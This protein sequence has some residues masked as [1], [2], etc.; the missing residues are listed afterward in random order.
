MSAREQSLSE[1]ARWEAR[2]ATPEYAFGKEP[3]Y[4]LKSCKTLLPRSGRAL[5][6]AD[7]EGRNG[8]WLAQQGLEVLSLDFSPAAQRK[9][10]AL[11]AERQVEIEF[12]QVDVDACDYQEP[13]FQAMGQ[14]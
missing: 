10:R 8:I 1:Y 11:A 2:F 7:G 9:T 14:T 3:N 12:V 5:A 4:F 6:I 13:A